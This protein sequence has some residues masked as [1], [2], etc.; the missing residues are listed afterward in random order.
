MANTNPSM[1]FS[2]EHEG[3]AFPTRDDKA[4]FGFQPLDL[5]LIDD[6]HDEQVERTIEDTDEDDASHQRPVDNRLNPT[7]VFEGEDT[8]DLIDELQKPLLLASRYEREG[9]GVGDNVGIPWRHRDFPAVQ[10][11]FSEACIDLSDDFVG[12]VQLLED[13]FEDFDTEFSYVLSPRDQGRLERFT[14]LD[15]YVD[16]VSGGAIV[17]FPEIYGIDCVKLRPENF[18][19]TLHLYQQ[20][21]TAPR[22]GRDIEE[23]GEQERYG[24]TIN[25]NYDEEP[26]DAL[27][28]SLERHEFDTERDYHHPSIIPEEFQ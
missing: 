24:H 2:V 27:E 5:F 3:E 22:Q 25:L 11:E 13:G 19:A 28:E 10:R 21:V 4:E 15:D 18:E 7:V 14:E 6:L 8:E 16:Q 23:I 9:Y 17:A 1:D 20:E 12:F 26:I